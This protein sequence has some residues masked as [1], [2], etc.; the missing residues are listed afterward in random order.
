MVFKVKSFFS[1][2]I[3]FSC[4]KTVFSEN[5]TMGI[6]SNK[7]LVGQPI[8]K[9]II[10]LI[11]RGKFNALTIELETDKYYKAFYS[12]DQLITMLFG[13]FS[14]CDSMG[15]VCDGMRAMSGKLSYLEM[16]SS[17]AKSTAG[18]ALRN[19]PEELFRLFYF[20]LVRHYSKIMSV[21]RKKS[22]ER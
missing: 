6:D 21:S 5:D 20:V 18:D 22:T 12:W 14:R 8:Y 3:F 1:K 16:D 10:D 13:I 2:V 17:P 9:Q 15:E 11:P 4:L 7:Y 19:R